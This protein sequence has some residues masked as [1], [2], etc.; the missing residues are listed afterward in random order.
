MSKTATEKQGV[1]TTGDTTAANNQ[2]K[3]PSIGTASTTGTPS[4]EKQGV[5]TAGDTDTTTSRRTPHCAKYERFEIDSESRYN[6][7]QR[8]VQK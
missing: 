8:N 7:E 5:S 3:S 6:A 2:I 1:P 4:T